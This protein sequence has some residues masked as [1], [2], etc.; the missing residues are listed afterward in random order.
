MITG[1]IT[2][3][4]LDKRLQKLIKRTRDILPLTEKIAGGMFAST[5][6]NFEQEGRPRWK[7]LSEDT[8]DNRTKIKKWPGS[9]LQVSG[10]LK[11]SI[12][13]KHTNSYALVGT[14]LN[15][16]AIH[17]FGGKAGRNRKVLIPARP[18]LKL[19][20]KERRMILTDVTKWMAGD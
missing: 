20:A 3:K 9:I 5:A 7:G 18:F 11:K 6:E 16:A 13:Q 8:I 15:Y 10:E 4:G 19:S 14:N 1:S 2:Y 17:Q 12:N